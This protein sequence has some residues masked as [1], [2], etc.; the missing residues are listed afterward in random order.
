MNGPRIKTRLTTALC[1]LFFFTLCAVPVYADR[2]DD[3]KEKGTVLAGTTELDRDSYVDPNAYEMEPIE[4]PLLLIGLD[5]GEGAVYDAAFINAMSQGFLLCSYNEARELKPYA[6][7]DA[8]ELHVCRLW[9]WHALL[10]QRFDTMELA[11]NA[12]Q[13]TEGLAF[14]LDGEARVLVG[15]FE[16]A[17]EAER[18]IADRGLKAK[19][20][21]DR[22]SGVF[23]GDWRLVDLVQEPG[24]VALRCVGEDETL[25]YHG[26]EVYRG[27]FLLRPTGDGRFTVINTVSLEDYVK[28]VIPYE[29][30]SLWPFEALR[31]QA[32]CARSYAA[33]HLNE[34]ADDYGFDLTDDTESQVYRGLAEADTMTDAAVDSTAGLFVRYEG[35]LCEVYYFASDG[36]ATEDGFRIFGVDQP[37]LAGKLDPFEQAVDEQILHWQRWRSGEDIARM[38]ARMGY[39]TAE[40]VGVEPEY[41]ELGNVVAMRYTDAEGKTLYLETRDSYKYLSLNSARFHVERDEDGDFVFSG[42]GFGHNCGMSQ[43]GAYAMA[44]CYGYDCE[45]IIRFYFTGAY[46]G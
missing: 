21:Q 36:G 25:C 41:S 23:D 13:E 17:D 24:T 33:G 9:R 22:A 34:Y 31:A 35:R 30:N 46:V 40:I 2:P 42:V 44:K 45:D 27:G 15:S 6:Q 19:V 29:M 39:E 32:V 20:W 38:L 18:I 16:T 8:N 4:I 37:Y 11:R 26:G 12:A 43:W 3:V 14:L 7:T 28:G 1:A 5:Y 10:E